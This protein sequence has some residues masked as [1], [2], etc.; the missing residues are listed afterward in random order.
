MR[1]SEQ[2]Y[3]SASTADPQNIEKLFDWITILRDISE[4][5]IFED[6]KFRVLELI[7]EKCSSIILQNPEN[8]IYTSNSLYFWCKS[9]SDI[10]EYC[11]YKQRGTFLESFVTAIA[12]VDPN[13]QIN[14]RT[15]DACRQMSKLVS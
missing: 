8:R 9:I 11:N 13:L 3:S 2:G 7:L 1:V 4:L 12:N 14:V 6:E 15:L 10:W 5:T